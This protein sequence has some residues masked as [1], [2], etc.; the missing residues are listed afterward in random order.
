MERAT[1]NLM[2]LYAIVCFF[3]VAGVAMNII[4]VFNLESIEDPKLT[5]EIEQGLV[6]GFYILALIYLVIAL[7]ALGAILK[8]NFSKPFLIVLALLLIVTFAFGPYLFDLFLD[9]AA[10]DVNSQE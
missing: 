3:S 9:G 10:F 8:K 5:E 1:R 4:P 7:S 2:I 6:K